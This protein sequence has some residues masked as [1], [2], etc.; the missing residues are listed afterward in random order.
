MRSMRWPT[1]TLRWPRSASRS[2]PQR[3]WTC[4]R[5]HSSVL[6]TPKAKHSLRSCPC[7]IDRTSAPHGDP[8]TGSSAHAPAAV[9]ITPIRGDPGREGSVE[10]RPPPSAACVAQQ[11]GPVA[12]GGT[13]TSRRRPC[14]GARGCWRA[15][16]GRCSRWT[17]GC[18]SWRR[19]STPCGRWESKASRGFCSTK[20][21]RLPSRSWRIT[22]TPC[23]RCGRRKPQIPAGCAPS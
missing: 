18:R 23:G 17:A 4:C 11:P 16:S 9:C 22:S 2:G 5:P 1:T 10:T 3:P 19:T 20:C 14:S 6:Q 13:R 12:T 8:G 15:T 7:S 21:C